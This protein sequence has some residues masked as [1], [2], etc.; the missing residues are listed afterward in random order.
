MEATKHNLT[1]TLRRVPL[2][3]DLSTEE[4]SMIAEHVTHLPYERGSLIFSEGDVCRELL[5]IEQGSAAD[6]Q[7]SPEWQAA[8]YWN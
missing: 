5:I 4:I 1:T 6:R 7:I 2:F 8:A 3:A